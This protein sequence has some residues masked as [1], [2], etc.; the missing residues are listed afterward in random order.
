VRLLLR[1]MTQATG[2]LASA[3]FVFVRSVNDPAYVVNT[4]PL[5]G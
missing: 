2:V 1:G 3:I 4:T 5:T